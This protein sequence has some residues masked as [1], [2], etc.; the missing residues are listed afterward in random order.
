M[1]YSG[2]L[3][4]AAPV[5]LAQG[6]T[7][8]TLLSGSISCT[9]DISGALLGQLKQ[10]QANIS[11]IPLPTS[12]AECILSLHR[13]CDQPG[14]PASGAGDAEKVSP[15]FLCLP[16][17]ATP[18]GPRGHSANPARPLGGGAVWRQSRCHCQSIRE[19][20]A[21]SGKTRKAVADEPVPAPFS[22][23]SLSIRISMVKQ[24]KTGFNYL[25]STSIM[26]FSQ[27]TVIQPILLSCSLSPMSPGSFS[28]ILPSIS[29]PLSLL[30]P[31]EWKFPEDSDYARSLKATF[32]GVQGNTASPPVQQ[33][34]ILSSIKGSSDW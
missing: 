25:S 9:E 23:K 29:S 11:I 15:P 31:Q 33:R 14:C 4:R 8:A 20:R 28:F 32:P 34:R 10:L 19:S 13:W 26:Q 3:P 1:G 22:G 12:S 30:F 24:F 16:S 21:C 2:L 5:H 17:K 18:K 27:G 6:Q 7:F